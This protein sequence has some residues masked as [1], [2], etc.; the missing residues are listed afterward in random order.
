MCF[1]VVDLGIVVFLHERRV[2]GKGN[3]YKM[4]K[5]QKTFDILRRTLYYIGNLFVY[6]SHPLNKERQERA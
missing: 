3:L 2:P 5:N 4:M 6:L 1:S